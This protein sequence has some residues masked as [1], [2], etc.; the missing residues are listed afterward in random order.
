MPEYILPT[1]D[2][3]E[4]FQD[5]PQFVQGYIECAFFCDANPDEPELEDATFSD[6]A[7]E[8][9]ERIKLDCTQFEE[10]A[11]ADLVRAYDSGDYDAMQAGRDFW[12]TRNH[13]GVG[14]WDRPQLDADGLGDKLTAHSD[15][16]GETGLYRG[17][18][19]RVYLY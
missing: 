4:K 11:R 6:L 1:G 10:L 13:H 15:G 18:D 19:G 3:S 14:F 9:L 2:E 8:A 12:F 5:L 7:P 17:D 16:F